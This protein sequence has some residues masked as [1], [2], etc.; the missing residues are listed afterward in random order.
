MEVKIIMTA[1]KRILV[2][3]ATYNGQSYLKEQIDSILNQK[4]VK[5]DILISDDSSTDNTLSIL[6]EY[7]KNKNIKFYKSKCGSAQKNFY[8]LINNADTSYD[9]YA[10]SD[11]DDLW[12]EDK[13]YSAIKELDKYDS[14]IPILYSGI[15]IPVDANLNP[16]VKKEYHH[17]LVDSFE[18]S[19][20]ASNA[21]G[22]T[23]VFNNYFL[24]KI[25]N[26]TS[27]QPMMHDGWLH[28]TCLL[29]NGK[30]IFDKVPHMYYRQHE[31]NVFA[32]LGKN[33]SLIK[34]IKNKLHT[35]FFN[36][37]DFYLRTNIVDEWICNFKDDISSEKLKTLED[38]KNI[39]KS[40]KI[41]FKIL[42]SRKY[43]SPYKKDYLKFI[44]LL[45]IKKI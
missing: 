38:L 14:N 17:Y 34:K 6:E 28:K 7:K 8:N 36:K 26:K 31:N 9:Y 5:V 10:L 15:S 1:E 41:R 20:I 22:C 25:K 3:I 40:I 11:Q 37:N 24:K 29:L 35:T 27:N 21:Q 4:K 2:L 32:S 30:V 39:N 45:L 33:D 16:I 18:S 23:I 43:K 19:M 13:L 12:C 42:F 44:Y